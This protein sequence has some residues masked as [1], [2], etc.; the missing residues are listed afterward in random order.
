MT[1]RRLILR[2]LQPI[3]A[4][5]TVGFVDLYIPR[6]ASWSLVFPKTVWISD[7]KGERVE[8]FYGYPFHFA[9]ADD[10]IAF[11]RV[12]LAAARDLAATR[13]QLTVPSKPHR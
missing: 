2:N 12:A 11:Q 7:E 1:D 3:A 9:A 13:N 8:I 10:G 6:D 4:G 5:R